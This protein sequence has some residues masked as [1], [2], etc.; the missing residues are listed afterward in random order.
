[1]ESTTMLHPTAE[2]FEREVLGSPV[3]VLVD[4]WAPWCPPCRML[5]PELEKLAA[6]LGASARI[7]TVNVDEEP[8]LAQMFNV[9]GIPFLALIKNG[10]VVD[11]WTGY[12]PQ[13]AMSA[14]IRPHVPAAG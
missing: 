1:M 12:A 8:E 13:A 11:A 4:F 9:S 7:A 5:K 14:R 3:P 6:E 10:K 2:T